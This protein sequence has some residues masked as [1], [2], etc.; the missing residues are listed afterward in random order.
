MQNI[1]G[2]EEKEEDNK[3]GRFIAAVL[4]L[5]DCR[6]AVVVFLNEGYNSRSMPALT[7]AV[8]IT[9][10]KAS[11]AY[12]LHPAMY[13]LLSE[14][15]MPQRPSQLA[16]PMPETCKQFQHQEVF[17]YPCDCTISFLQGPLDGHTS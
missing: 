12:S 13:S 8:L 15:L 17:N 16:L 4:S 1:R 6:L 3:G 11:S 5:L 2:F 9:S 7:T 10:V 14:A